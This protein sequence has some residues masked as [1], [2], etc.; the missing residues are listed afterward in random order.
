MGIS[1]FVILTTE[2]T[3]VYT[4]GHR[5]NRGL[6]RGPQRIYSLYLFTNL[7]IPLTNLRTLKLINSPYL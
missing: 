1:V 4:E 5:G 6:H 2:E 3:E 7:L